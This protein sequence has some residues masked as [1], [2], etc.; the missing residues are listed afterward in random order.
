MSFPHI[1]ASSVI[2]VDDEEWGQRPVL[3]V[4][5]ERTRKIQIQFLR[6]FLRDRIAGYKVPDEIIVLKKMP[7]ATIEKIDLPSLQSYYH[8]QKN[9]K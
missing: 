6:Q 1:T 7:R 8:E 4:E 9:Q 3:F 2:A 5:I